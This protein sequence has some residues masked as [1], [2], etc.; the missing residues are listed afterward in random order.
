MKGHIEMNDPSSG[1]MDDEENIQDAEGEGRDGEEIHGGDGFPVISEKRNPFFYLVFIGS[2]F[3][4]ISGNGSFG[5]TETELQELT[6]NP[7]CSP[8]GIFCFHLPHQVSDFPFS[9]R[10]A[11]SFSG[12]RYVVPIFFERPPVPFDDG[13]GLNNDEGIFPFGPEPA[14]QDPED[15]V[16]RCYFRF[17]ISFFEDGELLPKGDVFKHKGRARAEG[18]RERAAKGHHP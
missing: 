7:G 17:V 12:L 11:R 15:T 14:E 5:D 1:V 2:C 16:E 9:L 13:I 6:M 4:E 18:G 10:A 8:G 3:R